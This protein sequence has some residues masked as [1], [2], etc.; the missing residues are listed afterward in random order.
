VAIVVFGGILLFALFVIVIVI[1]TPTKPKQKRPKP[2]PI[3][4][5]KGNRL[6]NQSKENAVHSVS[7][8]VQRTFDP[9]DTSA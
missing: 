7:K 3:G 4:Q 1:L 6:E 8:V 5:L 2:H 9:S